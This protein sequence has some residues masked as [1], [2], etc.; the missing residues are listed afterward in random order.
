MKRYW[1]DAMEVTEEEAEKVKR[2]NAEYMA[3]AESLNL[4]ERGAVEQ[5]FALMDKCKLIIITGI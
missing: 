1:I 4:K 3:L 5:M 2:Q